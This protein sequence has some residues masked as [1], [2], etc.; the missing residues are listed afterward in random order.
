MAYPQIVMA[1][2]T[3]LFCVSVGLIALVW[4][5]TMQ[6]YAVKRCTRFLIWP[7]PLLGWMNTSAYIVYLRFSGIVFLCFGFFVLL[8]AL[9]SKK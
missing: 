7:N 1:A 3:C 6:R 8:A 5:E 4:P 2:V 9:T